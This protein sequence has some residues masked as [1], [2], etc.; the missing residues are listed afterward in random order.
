MGTFRNINFKTSRLTGWRSLYLLNTTF[1]VKN[2]GIASKA[3]NDSNRGN[4]I[5]SMLVDIFNELDLS[6]SHYQFSDDSRA[7]VVNG[8][9]DQGKT[10][11]SVEN[12][13]KF[14]F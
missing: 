8:C 12:Y 6:K 5:L 10:E 14:Q 7:A 9:N 2:S 11:L 1:Q 4:H 13:Q 3:S